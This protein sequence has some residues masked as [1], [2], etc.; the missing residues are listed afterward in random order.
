MVVLF[1]G[2]GELELGR[3]FSA[4]QETLEA[5]AGAAPEAKQVPGC[6]GAEATGASEP[7]TEAADQP[8]SAFAAQQEVD[9]EAE[10]EHEEDETRDAA[11]GV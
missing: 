4:L 11:W 8:R 6:L 1:V 2:V 10:D 9:G 7:T 5:Q 3:A